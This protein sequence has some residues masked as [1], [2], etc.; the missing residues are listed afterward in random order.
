MFAASPRIRA[1]CAP[2]SRAHTA[3][4]KTLR[5]H[6]GEHAS[7][8]GASACGCCGVC[9]DGAL[10]AQPQWS[11]GRARRAHIVRSVVE[12]LVSPGCATHNHSRG[13]VA[14]RTQSKSRGTERMVHMCRFARRR[15]G[16]ATAPRVCVR[17]GAQANACPTGMQRVPI[18]GRACQWAAV[19]RAPYLGR[20]HDGLY[21]VRVP[22]VLVGCARTCLV[23]LTRRVGRR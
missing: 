9:A 13:R 16:R 7:M 1:Q 18:E 23:P 2:R 6:R 21:A 19:H 5:P 22:T 3:R 11:S 8:G 15:R 10:T 12:T 4:T 20:P 17:A 14:P